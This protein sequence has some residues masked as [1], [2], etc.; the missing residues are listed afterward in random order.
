MMKKAVKILLFIFCSHLLYASQTQDFET[1][2]IDHIYE[3]ELQALESKLNDRNINK[4][5]DGHTLIHHTLIAG[6]EEILNF[7][8]ENGAEPNQY[9]SSIG[10]YDIDHT[11]PLIVA[12]R[13]DLLNCVKLLLKHG[14][15]PDKYSTANYSNFKLQLNER[16]TFF[17]VDM[18][19]ST[20]PTITAGNHGNLKIFQLLITYG[21]DPFKIKDS[22]GNN[23]L[24]R[25]FFEQNFGVFNYLLNNQPEHGYNPIPDNAEK[26]ITDNGFVYYYLPERSQMPENYTGRFQ[27]WVGI[28]N[29]GKRFLN[30]YLINGKPKWISLYDWENKSISFCHYN[31]LGEVQKYSNIE[32]CSEFVIEF[33]TGVLRNE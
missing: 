24:D 21:G 30:M 32:N 29:I 23:A 22:R 20:T 12:I 6:N 14:A 16:M 11:V 18:A 9:I 27:A 31:S 33:A 1:E 13:L 17:G 25:A 3:N 8:L 5:Y 2:I 19:E 4:Y 26:E 10:I 15:D 7:L 28:D